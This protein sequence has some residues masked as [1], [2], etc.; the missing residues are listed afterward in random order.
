MI[1]TQS[2]PLALYIQIT[3]NFSNRL[4]SPNGL[5]RLIASDF[6]AQNYQNAEDTALLLYRGTNIGYT[7]A[8]DRTQLGDRCATVVAKWS[9]SLRE[10]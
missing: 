1:D 6:S 8:T 10:T 3:F 2:I 5:E 9:R 4:I 7:I